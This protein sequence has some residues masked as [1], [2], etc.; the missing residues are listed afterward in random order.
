MSC[1]S[2]TVES[3]ALANKQTTQLLELSTYTEADNFSCPLLELPMMLVIPF[4]CVIHHNYICMPIDSTQ[5]WILAAIISSCFIF[6]LCFAV[7]AI[8]WKEQVEDYGPGPFNITKYFRN[9]WVASVLP[10]TC[11][12]IKKILFC[13]IHSIFTK[14]FCIKESFID[15]TRSNHD[16]ASNILH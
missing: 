1:P 8:S 13:D 12:S 9:M 16:V 4:P 14:A 2:L 5:F 6:C 10:D 3:L 15:A 11:S 7:F